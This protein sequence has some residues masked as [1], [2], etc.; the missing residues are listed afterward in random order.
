MSIDLYKSLNQ[1]TDFGLRN[2]IQRSAVS[3]PSNIA[4]GYERNSNKEFVQFL[5][6]AKG[7]C[8]ELRT[9]LYIAMKTGLLGK[10]HGVEFIERSRKIS[11]ML[12]KLI[13]V[14]KERF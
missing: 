1:A 10:E 14:R 7:S 9:Q 4:E 6:I 3:I 12:Y 8:S 2:H 13:E 5:H 11:S